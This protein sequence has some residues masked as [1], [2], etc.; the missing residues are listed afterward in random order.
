MITDSLTIS[1]RHYLSITHLSAASLAA[2]QCK[3]IED[4]ARVAPPTSDRRRAHG[5]SAITSI[6]LSA[7]F[8][9]A[10]I[11]ELFSDCADAQRGSKALKLTAHELM[12]QLWQRGIPRTA[13]YSILQKYAVALLL[14]GREAMPIGANPHQDA[15][16]LVELRNA[17]IHF[18]PETTVAFTDD[19]ATK[20][21]KFEGRLRG[22]FA[23][24]TLTGQGNPF[25]PDKVLGAGGAAW[26]VKSA[27]NFT[28]EFFSKM[29]SEATYEH[30]RV[31][32][33][34]R[35]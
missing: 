33:L 13:S 3:A 26:A 19:E 14:N 25:F 24:S 6:I 8:L 1:I 11:N 34:G 27:V 28:D 2:A 31:E 16:A 22:K 17:L 12:G 20:Q 23:P 7:A 9:E 18:E 5:A 15:Q 35:L 21:H 4:E 29:G 32:F 10:T 30:V